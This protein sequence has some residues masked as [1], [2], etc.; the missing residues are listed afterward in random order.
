MRTLFDYE[1]QRDVDLSFKENM[2]I[3][4]HPA[5]DPSSAWWYGMLVDGGNKGWFPHDYVKEMQS[6][7]TSPSPSWVDPNAIDVRARALYS[8]AGTTDEELPFAEGDE[9]VVVDKDEDQDWW[10]TEKAGIVFLVPSTY[11]EVIG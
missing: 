8:Y 6:R 1:G 2:V 10:K 11:L 9:L 4:A 7:S 3:I 5:K